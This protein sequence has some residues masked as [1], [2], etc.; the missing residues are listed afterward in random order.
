M[1]RSNR[2][3]RSQELPMSLDTIGVGSKVKY[4][5]KWWKVE[6]VYPGGKVYFL[7]RKNEFAD[8][9]ARHELKGHRR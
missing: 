4:Q 9:V 6:K 7:G 3:R 2:P 8:M 5:R 1:G